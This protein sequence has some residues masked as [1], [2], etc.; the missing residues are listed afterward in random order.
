MSESDPPP[1]RGGNVPGGDQHPG[2][3]TEP[4]VQFGRFGALGAFVT[5]LLGP[6]MGDPHAYDVPRPRVGRHH[7]HHVHTGRGG[8]FSDP[9]VVSLTATQISELPRVVIVDGDLLYWP[10]PGARIPETSPS[11]VDVAAGTLDDAEEGSVWTRCPICMES[12]YSYQGRDLPDWDSQS[13]PD[14]SPAGILHGLIEGKVSGRISVEP[15]LQLPCGHHFHE[16]C[17]SQ[18][19]STS[20]RCP[21]CRVDVR[22][23]LRRPPPPLRRP[24]LPRFLGR[25]DVTTAAVTTT[26][27]TD[28]LG[29]FDELA[30]NLPEPEPSHPSG[31]SKTE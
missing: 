11:F 26:A 18:W 27:T 22:D 17:I 10:S 20:V 19:L 16:A 25:E 14:G 4:Q 24:P 21:T 5:S 15:L 8:A 2:H 29:D 23:A 28:S 31:K 7:H 12:F 6:I 1:P 9:V 30:E 13:A 3:R